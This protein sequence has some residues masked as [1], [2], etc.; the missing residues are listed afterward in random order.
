MLVTTM[1]RAFGSG[2]PGT[3]NLSNCS[4]AVTMSAL[5]ELEKLHRLIADSLFNHTASREV[6]QTCTMRRIELNP[7]S[8]P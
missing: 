4:V 5:F 3:K 7:I 6:Q 2:S 8:V 1:L